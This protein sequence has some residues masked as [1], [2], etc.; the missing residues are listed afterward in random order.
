MLR[1]NLDHYDTNTHN[2]LTETDTRFTTHCRQAEPEFI[3]TRC[4]PS[5]GSFWL[6]PT[7]KDKMAIIIAQPLSLAKN[8]VSIVAIANAAIPDR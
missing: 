1:F 6:L 4:R 7:C 8:V 3:L 2:R 5:P